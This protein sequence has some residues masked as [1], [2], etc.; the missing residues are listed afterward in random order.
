MSGSAGTSSASST[1]SGPARAQHPLEAVTSVMRQAPGATAVKDAVDGVVGGVRDTVGLVT[2]HARRVAAHAGEGLLGAAGAAMAWLT[3]PL[4]GG[5]SSAEGRPATAKEVR[6]ATAKA[7]RPQPKPAA[8]RATGRRTAAKRAT[9]KPTAPKPA[10]KPASRPTATPKAA[11]PKAA[12]TAKT[13]KTA[14][15]TTSRT[16]AGAPRT[17]STATAT[18]ATGRRASGTRRTA[19]ASPAAERAS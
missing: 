16:T 15:K 12:E 2:P 1:P 19:S 9:P 4:R 18:P 6:P 5:D 17:R 8:K 10:A 11:K 3:Q 14:A 13:A 7:E